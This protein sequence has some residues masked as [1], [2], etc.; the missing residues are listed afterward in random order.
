MMHT[1]RYWNPE[2]KKHTSGKGPGGRAYSAFP[3][4]WD[5]DGDFDLLVGTDKGRMFLRINEGTK[6]QPAFAEKLVDTR[7][8]VPGGY[9]MPVAADWDGDGRWDLVSG[10]QDGAIFWFRNVGKPGEPKFEASRQL[11]NGSDGAEDKPARRTQVDVADFDGD[12]DMDLLAGDMSMKQEGGKYTWHG[13]I[14]LYRRA[15]SPE[16]SAQPAAATR[17]STARRLR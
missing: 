7:I 3:I 17:G 14:W 15:G 10:S 9:A 12:G 6:R 2:S 16:I 13:W 11:V 8:Q 1:G 5:A 4:D